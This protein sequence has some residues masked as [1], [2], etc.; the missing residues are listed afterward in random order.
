MAQLVIF[1]AGDIA[2]LAHYYFTRDS[3]HTVAAFTVDSAYRSGET[4]LELPL[5]DFERVTQTYPPSEYSMFIALSYARMNKVRAEKYH[6]AKAIG[7]HL[8]SYIS[9]R[10]T[11]L[12]DYP[13][14]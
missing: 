3:D 6:Q 4:F 5:V 12:S 1:G 7:Y 9:S 2:R 8:L 14:G 13:I 10:C 11:F